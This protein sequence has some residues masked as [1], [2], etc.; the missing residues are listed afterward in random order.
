MVDAN[1]DNYYE[2]LDEDEFREIMEKIP[3]S[4]VDRLPPAKRRKVVEEVGKRYF[5]D[6]SPL[7]TF[8]KF[9]F[10]L[11]RFHLN[12]IPKPSKA[13]SSQRASFQLVPTGL[14][15]RSASISF[16]VLLGCLFGC[17]CCSMTV[18]LFVCC[19]PRLDMLSPLIRFH[20]GLVKETLAADI[21]H[22][23][24]DEG[25]KNQEKLRAYF[26]GCVVLFRFCMAFLPVL[27][28]LLL[29]F[30]FHSE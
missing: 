27:I 16:I 10:Y 8:R 12:E 3:D 5:A 15:S 20:G 4:I 26:E 19:P 11:D 25:R 9:T 23:V 22:V 17:F 21:T 24:I 2:N 7:G 14:D 18:C 1:G 6:N 30:L 13:A 28:L 29:P